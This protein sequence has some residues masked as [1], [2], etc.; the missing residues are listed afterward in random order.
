[1]LRFQL[2]GRTGVKRA[3][4]AETAHH[5][6]STIREGTVNTIVFDLMARYEDF[7]SIALSIFHIRQEFPE[8]V[9]GLLADPDE[10]MTKAKEAEPDVAARLGHYYRISRKLDRSEVDRFIELCQR[11]HADTISKRLKTVRYKYDVAL[12]FAGEQREY[13]EELANIFKAQGVRVFY[14]DFEQ[15]SLWGKDLFE[16]LYRVH[17]EDSRYC[18]IFVSKEYATTMWTVHERRAAQER[19]LKNRDSEYLLPIRVDETRLPGLPDTVAYLSVKMGVREIG[20]LFIRK[21]GAT[22]GQL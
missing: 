4:Q 11:W 20:R 13:A 12:S 6:W 2:T 19:V 5:G 1:M 3:T 17:S 16:H 22:I 15:A 14:D 9:I 21:L 10:F 7:D 18:I 8:I